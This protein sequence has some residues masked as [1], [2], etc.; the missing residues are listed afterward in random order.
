MIRIKDIRRKLDVKKILDF[1]EKEIKGKFETDYPNEQQIRKYK[2]YGSELIEKDKFMYAH[3][4]III[5][6][7]MHC[8]VSTQKT[9]E[10]RSKLAFS[11]Y[12]ITLTKEQSLLKSVMDAFEGEY[13]QTQ[14]SVLG[15]RFGL[16]VHDYKRAI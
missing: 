4:C 7:I 3:E 11:H 15:Y 2:R 14:N 6:V 16:Y 10:F 12:Y 13:M 8:R 9:I 5:P 1:F